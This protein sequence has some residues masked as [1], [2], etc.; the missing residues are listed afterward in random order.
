MQHHVDEEE[1]ELWLEAA[2]PQ[3][4]EHLGEDLVE[5]RKTIL[6]QLE[7]ARDVGLASGTVTYA[8]KNPTN[9]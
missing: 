1:R 3:T 4:V 7:E 5:R 8:T 2:V 9:S 6:A